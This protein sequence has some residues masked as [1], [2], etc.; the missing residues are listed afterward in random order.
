MASISPP[1]VEVIQEFVS[2]SP[3][4]IQPFLTTVLVGPAFQVVDAFDDNGN[5][6]DEAFAGTYRDGQGTIAYDLPNLVAEASLAGFEDDVRVFLVYGTEVRE[7][8]SVND[9]SVLVDNGTGDF[10]PG[11]PDTFTDATQLYLQIGVEAGDFVRLTYLGE[12]VDIEI[13]DVVSDTVLEL[14]DSVVGEV[15]T[16]V[17]Y[18]IV[19]SPA[20]FI[21]DATTQA[22]AELGV[23]ADFIRFTAQLLKTDGLTAGDYLGDAGDALSL[24]ITDSEHFL[25]GTDGATGDTIFTSATAAFLTSVGSRGAASGK[26]ILVGAAGDGDVFRDVLYSVSDTQIIIETGEGVGLSGQTYRVMDEADTGTNGA[27]DVTGNTFT[28]IGESFLTTIPNTA[29]APDQVTYIELEGVGTYPVTNV[30][31]NTQ[32]TITGTVA[33]QSL[34]GQAYTV[35]L[36]VATAADGATGALTDF[37]SISADFTTLADDSTESVNLGGTEARALTASAVVDADN[38]T[39]AAAFSGSGSDL[40]FSVVATTAALTLSFDL[41]A[42][43]VTIQLERTAGVTG[44]TYA[45]INTAITSDLDPSYNSVVTDAI[46]SVLGGSVGTGLVSILEADLPISLQFDGGSSNEQLLIDA[47]LLGSGTPTASVYVSYKALRVDLSDQSANAALWEIASQ[48]QRESL[49]GPAT[50][51]NPL[52]LAVFQAL[53]NSPTRAIK[54]LGVSEVS[55]SKP[56][57]TPGAYASAFDFLSSEVVHLIVPLTQDPTVHQSLAAH[58]TALSASD[59]KAERIGF[60]NTTMPLFTNAA[61]VGSGS[62]GNTGTSFA[63]NATA[64]F[65]TSVDFSAAGAQAGDILVVTALAA[66]SAELDAVDGTVG[67]LYGLPITSIKS[68]DNFTLVLDASGLTDTDWNSLVDVSWALYRP[69]TSIVQA[70]DQAEVIAQTGEGFANRRVFHHWPDLCTFDVDGTEQLQPGFY[71]AAGWAGKANES[72]PERGFSRTQVSGYLSLRN[73]N[74]YFS[75]AQLDRMAGGGTWISIQESQ[76]AP[77]KCRHQLST[78]TSSI[79]KQEFSITRVV[80][81]TAIYLRQGLDRQVGKFNI[82]QSYLDGLA[83]T[84]Q[85]LLRALV[86]SGKLISAS[87]VS[88]E[89]DSV[90]PDKINVVIA[91]GVPYPCNLIEI[92]LQ[93]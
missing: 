88:L 58:V 54:A 83:S 20:E 48:D 76:N 82:T 34:T 36:E 22:N 4:V 42:D 71:L 13:T 55:A 45:E 9:T 65:E 84:I 86:E 90:R 62:S 73:S 28:A 27:T 78:D 39:V 63:L 61:V 46:G 29:G 7:L 51:D 8:N 72:S 31:S 30:D 59:Q 41:D 16:G 75:K 80:D 12:V 14:A 19:R 91:I 67:P 10:A 50:I 18:D 81:Y 68:G 64:E 87:L 57:G 21:F 26:L 92:T 32:L 89:V 33:T 23:A 2:T 15:L 5:P 85:G 24:V 77:I 25:D 43:R 6:Q 52:S 69:G 11:T 49:L 44:S 47:D 1:G 53:V 17:T 3:P 74:T 38:L 93:V 35:G 60:F 79:E 40:A 56:F 37:V 66:E 70:V